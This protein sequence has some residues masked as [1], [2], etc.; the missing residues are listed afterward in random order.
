[1]FPPAL[2]VQPF[3]LC[4]LGLTNLVYWHAN[5]LFFLVPVGMVRYLRANLFC[6]EAAEVAVREG[7]E[8]AVGLLP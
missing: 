7:G 1:M 8:D 2:A 6:V 3:S 5:L 4:V